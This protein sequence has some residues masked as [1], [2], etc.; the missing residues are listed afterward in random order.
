VD[1]TE[2]NKLQSVQPCVPV[3]Q[4]FSFIREQE[5]MLT[6]LRIRHSC[7][8][9]G[10]PTP[11]ST[12]CGVPITISHIWKKGPF[13]EKCQHFHGQEMLRIIVGGE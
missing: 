5:V 6:Y 1:D 7:L 12:H 8:T 2:D 3:W 10:A 13:S 9:L 4:P 11:A